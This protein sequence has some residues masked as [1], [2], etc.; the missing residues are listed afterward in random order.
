ML[1]QYYRGGNDYISEHSDKTL[2]IVPGSFI[3]NVSLGAQRTMILRTKK[4][5]KEWMEREKGNDKEKEQENSGKGPRR[6]SKQPGAPR[7]MQRIPLPHN[8][9]FVLGEATNRKWLHS[10]KQDKRLPSL[11][12]PEEA[13]CGGERIS[14]TF[15]HIGTFLGDCETKIW[16]Q[17]A[18][19]KSK[20]A[21]KP[22]LEDDPE[23]V[24]R[25]VFA[26]GKENHQG[27]EFDWEGVYGAGFDVLHF[28]NRLPKLLFGNQEDIGVIRVLLALSEK[29]VDIEAEE[30]RREEHS[31][32]SDDE[33]GEGNDDEDEVSFEDCDIDR[34][35]VNG[36]VPILFYLESFYSGKSAMGG[37]GSQLFPTPERHERGQYANVLSLLLESNSLWDAMK[38]YHQKTVSEPASSLPASPST[39]SP[40]ITKPGATN[41]TY[42]AALVTPSLKRLQTALDSFETR[43][44]HLSLGPSGVALGITKGNEDVCFG[45]V[46][47]NKCWS[48]A[49]CAIWPLL[50]KLETLRPE[51]ALWAE[52]GEDGRWSKLRD[53]YR[54]GW[55]RPQVRAVF[56]EEEQGSTTS[57]E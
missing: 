13:F 14:L 54:K 21:A 8:S 43:L 30:S 5:P 53:Y 2:D 26:F 36:S 57:V 16:G 3:V 55:D 38:G 32:T 39:E 41:G 9:M 48:A 56:A 34:T 19:S 18:T 10:I 46:G 31:A 44:H 37:I 33:T 12:S 27:E 11:L 28:M 6:V 35:T 49:D 1:I 45:G 15:R 22:V 4:D 24:E 50:R 17:G 20:E 51:G 47:M 42:C 29:G 7:T 23:E 52:I 25:M 40:D